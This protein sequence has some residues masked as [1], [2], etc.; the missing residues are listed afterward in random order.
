MGLFDGVLLATD[1][2]HSLTALDGSVSEKN[3]RAISAF[4]AEGGLFSVATGRAKVAL[5]R[6]VQTLPVNLPCILSNGALIYDFQTGD[7][8]HLCPLP[9][10]AGGPLKTLLSRY[11]KAGLEV[12]GLSSCH[13]FQANEYTERHLRNVGITPDSAPFSD[14]PFPW[15]KALFSGETELLLEIGGDVNRNFTEHFYAVLSTPSLLEIMNRDANKGKAVSRIARDAGARLVA[16][17][18][19]AEN[20]LPMLE[21]ADI[22]YIPENAHPSLKTRGFLPCAHCDKGAIASA[23]DDL[24]A[25]LSTRA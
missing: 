15:V 9:E 8:V 7:I 13:V 24:R 6:P 25:R 20:D 16:C 10:T 4:V 3:I 21:T 5:E 17:V 18:G 14:I 11:P 22:A 1:F 2:D 23:I 12:F 19:D